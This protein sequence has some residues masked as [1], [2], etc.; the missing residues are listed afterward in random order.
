M[1]NFALLEERSMKMESVKFILLINKPVFRQVVNEHLKTFEK[2]LNRKIDAQDL[3]EEMSKFGYQKTLKESEILKGI[4][5]G[6]GEQNA[7]LFEERIKF[8]YKPA[9]NLL[10]S[11]SEEPH[12]LIKNPTFFNKSDNDLTF[13]SLINFL[14]DPHSAETQE[15]REKYNE[16]D[17]KIFKNY[18]PDNILHISLQKLLE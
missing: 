14:V 5:L 16:A 18:K 1:E 9:F 15:L 3:L 7:R 10:R 11:Q 12:P 4:L 8:Y 13:F 6:Y 17:I 2:I